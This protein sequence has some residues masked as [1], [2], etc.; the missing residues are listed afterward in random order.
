MSPASST[1]RST[2]SNS[3]ARHDEV[4]RIDRDAVAADAG[5]RREAH[6]AE[7]LGGRG[8]DDLP[9]VEAHPLAQQRELVDERDVDVAEDVLEELREL[10]GVRRGELEDVV[11]D[12]PEE[13]RGAGRRGRGRGADEPR[14]ALRCAGRVAGVDPLRGERQVEV[15][16]GRQSGSLQLLA[17]RAGRGPREGRRLEDDE[18]AGA[19]VFADQRRGARAPAR[20]PGPSSWVIGVGTQTKID[21]GVA[22]A[23]VGSD[24]TTLRPA[25]EG[26]RESLVRDVVDRRAAGG[27]LGDARRRGRRY[28]RRRGRP[29]ERDRER[30]ARRSRGRRSRSAGGRSGRGARW[31]LL[32]VR[33]ASRFLRCV[34][35]EG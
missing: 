10:R 18:L 3:R 8:V 21:V 26:G 2:K 25:A 28:P 7:R 4:V 19:E 12:R 24:S 17:E 22:E 23:R 20:D 27:E 32:P 9:D 29:R 31:A 1:K 6:E 35:G 14:D 13:R 34:S 33:A 11:V 15:A 30:Q 5:A 16:A